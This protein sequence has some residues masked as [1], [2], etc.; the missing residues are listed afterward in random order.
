MKKVIWKEAIRT[1][2]DPQR[3]QHYLDQLKTTGAATILKNASAEQARILT[4]LLSGSQTLSEML[5][6]HPNWL[7]TLNPELLQYP[8]QEQ[9]IRREVNGWLRPFLQAG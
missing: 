4:A 9:G 6:A 1:C 7:S 5:I 8:R 3:A 2:A